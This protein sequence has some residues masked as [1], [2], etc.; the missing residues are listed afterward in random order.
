[1]GATNKVYLTAM[2][3]A[4]QKNLIEQ[5]ALI[6]RSKLTDMLRAIIDERCEIKLDEA[7]G[8]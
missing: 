7:G 2:V 5:L 4:S 8:L 1:M 3:S 6:N